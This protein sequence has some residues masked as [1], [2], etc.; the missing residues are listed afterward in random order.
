M[1][2]VQ[3]SLHPGLE[4]PK[5][6][7]I[8]EALEAMQVGLNAVN[9]KVRQFEFKNDDL[10]LVTPYV[11]QVEGNSGDV[12]LYEDFQVFFEEYSE[13]VNSQT[14]NEKRHKWTLHSQSFM[15]KNGEFTAS[16]Y[17]KM[18]KLRN[19]PARELLRRSM[20]VMNAYNDKFLPNYMWE[21][22]LA[23]PEEGLDYYETKG[24]LRN[25]TIDS[26][27]LY[28]YDETASDGAVTSNVKNH[29]WGIEGSAVSY[30]DLKHIKHQFSNYIDVDPNAIIMAGNLTS[31]DELE[32]IFQD[33]KT[34]D[35]VMIGGINIGSATGI[36]GLP[37]VRTSML[38]SYQIMFMVA[39]PTKPFIAQLVSDVDD[40]KGIN[41][42][43]EKINAKFETFEDINGG[44]Y[45]IEDIGNQVIA[46]HRI[47]F[48]DI[49][50]DRY[51]GNTS[52][53]MDSD[54]I[55]EIKGQ[56]KRLNRQWNTTVVKK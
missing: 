15:S 13:Y 30:E 32:T 45:V 3:G 42:E 52:R 33:T 8:N 56:R 20:A 24:A 49:T 2:N 14:Y 25:T 36:K 22:L 35:E 38:R 18:K 44:R 7:K 11:M 23:V 48:L 41:F 51:T 17:K 50:P 47:G 29:F 19:N 40:Y 27:M 21:A 43:T 55:D 37:F 9:D 53:A 31:E 39:D 54:G 16:W 1:G 28:E 4:I 10:K 6:I 26:N 5:G 46:G 12:L 34:L